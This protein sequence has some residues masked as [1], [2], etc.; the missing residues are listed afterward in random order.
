MKRKCRITLTL[1]LALLGASPILAAP[2]GTEPETKAGDATSPDLKAAQAA[3]LSV[4]DAIGIAEKHSNGGKVLEVSFKM[5]GGQPTYSLRTYQKSEV[6]EG[7]IDANSG[8]ILDP[9]DT[10]P[11]S[12]L[13][14]K[15]KAEL[16]GLRA[17]TTT[18]SQ[19]VNTAEEHAKGKAF[20]GG[21]EQAKGGVV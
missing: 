2:K 15:D 4:A 5:Q 11:E 10:T 1:T 18:L 21:L 19:A 9:G 6:W 20:S 13:D 17:A 7:S 3:K 16:A 8:A 14:D 12:D